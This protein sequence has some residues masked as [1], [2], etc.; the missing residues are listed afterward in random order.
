MEPVYR[1]RFD[2]SEWLAQQGK[3]SFSKTVVD[4]NSIEI[5]GNL[6]IVMA[7]VSVSVNQQVAKEGLLES[8]PPNQQQ[9]QMKWGWFYDDWYFMPDIIFGNHLEY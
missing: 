3:I 6:A 8:A 5:K 1:E 7:N 9:I 2:K 4:E